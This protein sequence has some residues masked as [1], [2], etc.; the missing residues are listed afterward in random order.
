MLQTIFNNRKNQKWIFASLLLISIGFYFFG[1]LDHDQIV[2]FIASENTPPTR[3]DIAFCETFKVNRK[4]P[5]SLKS[6]DYNDRCVD[7]INEGDFFEGGDFASDNIYIVTF[8]VIGLKKAGNFYYPLLKVKNH[9]KIN[10]FLVQLYFILLLI[11]I[12][13]TVYNAIN[14]LKEE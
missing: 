9:R 3:F 1:V 6:I 11:I 10:I 14:C 13:N 12:G 8:D 7:A 2:L 5:D 4:M